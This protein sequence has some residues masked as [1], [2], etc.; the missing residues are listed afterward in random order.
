MTGSLEPY[1]AYKPSGIEWLGEVPAHWEVCRLG[2]LG[3]FSK[4]NGGNKEDETY[5]GVPCIRYG[6]LYTTHRYFI[7]RSRSF[8]SPE[9]AP[10]Y[11][12]IK[13]GDLL[14]AASG[15]TIEDI[16]KSAVNLIPSDA[17][18]GG[19]V[20]LFRARREINARYLG[21][22]ADCQPSA[23][24][25]AAMGRGFTVIHIYPGQLKRLSLAL[26]PLPEQAAIARFLDH[27][28]RRIARCIGTKERLIALLEEYRQAVVSEA[29]TGRFD[30]RTGKPYPA[31][32][33]SGVEWLGEVPA[34]WE[35]RRLKHW[36]NINELVLSEDT[37]A[38]YTFDYLDIGAVG[39]GRLATMPQRS[40]F[41]GSPSRAR[42]IVRA[43]DTLVSTVRTY[44]KAV[45][46]YA[47]QPRGDLIA[48]T[49]FAVLT[50]KAD[51]HPKFVS[52]VCQSDSFTNRVTA[53]SVG[54]AY[55][56]IAE[57]RL[58]TLKVCA[59]PL[60][61]QA[62]IARFLDGKIEKVREGI[63]RA[64][65]E[66]D[67]LREYRTRLIAD[68]VTGKL[69]ARAAAAELPETDPLAAADGTDAPADADDAPVLDSPDRAA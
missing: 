61:E 31:Y 26:P 25:K 11:T 41:G 17:C 34:H 27:M 9:R 58:G 51:T 10:K 59:P 6:D 68:V 66:I 1:P 63:A 55:P 19:D 20:I 33:P 18:C 32:R 24:Y 16:G 14:F 21:Y 52:Y 22:A 65:G 35:V 56:A 54:I 47:G 49:G 29:V 64:Q 46:W 62:T 15:E 53:D 48:S 36:L 40:R 2:Q 12:P 44:L 13:F 39:A 45:W 38:E 4:G 42:R 50:P 60:P 30:V 8:V 43:G 3:T 5:S 28:D 69:D 37:D 57:T 67:L 23:T 7:K